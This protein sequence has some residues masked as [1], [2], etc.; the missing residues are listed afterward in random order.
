M[1]ALLPPVFRLCGRTPHGSLIPILRAG[2]GAEHRAHLVANAVCPPARG[3]QV[4][5]EDAPCT[6]PPPRPPLRGSWQEDSVQTVDSDVV[7]VRLHLTRA[8]VRQ[9]HINECKL[10]SERVREIL[11]RRRSDMAGGARAGGARAA[12]GAFGGPG[13][14]VG[15]RVGGRD[16][17][18][19]AR[20]LRHW[21]ESLKTSAPTRPRPRPAARRVLRD[22]AP[23]GGSGGGGSGA[24]RAQALTCAL[25]RPAAGSSST[26]APSTSSR[27]APP[28]PPPPPSY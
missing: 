9:L 22:S 14:A 15:E 19:R 17:Q 5:D 18:A 20:C 28:P 21:L 10:H 1:Q 7:L 2:W 27:P 6:R 12:G 26:A 8:A 25:P 23:C 16:V 11:E 13:D 4:K 24:P 3:P